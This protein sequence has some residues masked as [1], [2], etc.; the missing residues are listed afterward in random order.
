MSLSDK[1]DVA[2]SDEVIPVYDGKEKIQD[3]DL[4]AAVLLRGIID[5][6]DPSYHDKA[7]IRRWV[8]GSPR[9][10]GSYSWLL[11]LLG[12]EHYKEKFLDDK[13]NIRFKAL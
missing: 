11:E 4:W 13:V 10:L 6:K 2:T 7:E 1:Y 3:Y 9:Q 8:E 5:Y 12:L